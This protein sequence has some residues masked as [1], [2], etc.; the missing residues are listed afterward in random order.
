MKKPDRFPLRPPRRPSTAG[1]VALASLLAWGGPALAEKADRDKPIHLEADQANVDDAKQVATFV[2]NVVL[3]QGTLTIRAE[4]MVVKQDAAGFQYG[5]AWGNP[6]TFRQKREGYDEYVDGKGE[7]LEYDGRA[8]KV[9][10][11]NRAWLRRGQD[12]V[13]GS[14]ISYDATTEFFQVIGGGKDAITETNPRG[15]VRAVIQPKNKAQPAQPA[16]PVAIKPSDSL[17]PPKSE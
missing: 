7:R 4:R 10:F 15:R 9:Q 12:E 1:A 11:F 8:D 2:G 16:A 17:S 14:Y 5:T 6:A 3:I 13:S